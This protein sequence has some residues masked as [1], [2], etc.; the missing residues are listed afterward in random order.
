[1]NS[2]TYTLCITYSIPLNVRHPASICFVFR[3]FLRPLRDNRSERYCVVGLSGQTELSF[4]DHDNQAPLWCFHLNYPKVCISAC[5]TCSKMREWR[6]PRKND[7]RNGTNLMRRFLIILGSYCASCASGCVLSPRLTCC[8]HLIRPTVTWVRQRNKKSADVLSRND[9]KASIPESSRSDTLVL[10]DNTSPPS[11]SGLFCKPNV[12]TWWQ[13]SFFTWAYYPKSKRQKIQ[14]FW[15][16]VTAMK[17]YSRFRCHLIQGES[18]GPVHLSE[19]R[20]EVAETVKCCEWPPGA[21][22]QASSRREALHVCYI[23]CFIFFSIFSLR[24]RA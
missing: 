16:I 1:L 5:L 19:V 15:S 13:L 18:N 23:K 4:H 3:A 11:P 10:L 9:V 12:Y 17:C 6:C 7:N 2:L 22:A 20:A 24:Y 8:W 14:N 21:C